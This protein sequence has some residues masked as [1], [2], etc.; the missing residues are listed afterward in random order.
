MDRHILPHMACPSHSLP[1]PHY[2]WSF[3]ATA[4][5]PLETD[6]SDLQLSKTPCPDLS[7]LQALQLCMC[8]PVVRLSSMQGR[9]S[10]ITLRPT[11][12]HT[13]LNTPHCLTRNPDSSSSIWQACCFCCS[14]CCCCCTL[15][16]LWHW[17]HLPYGWAQA[18]EPSGSS[19]VPAAS[20][21]SQDSSNSGTGD[22]AAAP[23]AEGAGAT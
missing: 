1:A 4:R 6:L 19:C 20:S 22:S 8:A 2:N 15:R 21:S 11:L 9:Q 23:P 12:L 16:R 5:R 3:P 17:S 14:C 13:R 10:N 18:H 7:P